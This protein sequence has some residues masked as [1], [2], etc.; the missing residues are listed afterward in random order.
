MTAFPTDSNFEELLGKI[1]YSAANADKVIKSEEIARFTDMIADFWKE[2][3]D[4]ISRSFFECINLSY[5]TNNL[6]NE[7]KAS[8]TLYPRMYNDVFIELIMQTAYKIAAS[9]A[10]TNKSEIV[11]ISQL[12]NQLEK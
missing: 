7:I 10:G 11:F 6:M 12:R 5:D 4:A 9:S 1:F 3:Y 8:K 2:D